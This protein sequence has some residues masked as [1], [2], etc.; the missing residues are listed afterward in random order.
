MP[1]PADIT[2]QSNLPTRDSI[3]RLTACFTWPTNSEA[4]RPRL[5]Y[6]PPD[7]KIRI[8]WT[9]PQHKA[10]LSAQTQLD[11]L[12]GMRCRDLLNDQE[13]IREKNILTSKINGL[14]AKQR[15]TEN[16]AERW[17][18]LAEKAFDFAASAREAFVNGDKETKR[19]TLMSLGSN[20]ILMDGKLS[21]K[22]N[23]WLQPIG[24]A[25]PSLEEEFLRL[26]PAD[27]RMNKGRTE[28]F[29][30]VRSRW[31]PGRDSNPQPSG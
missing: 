18:G 14:K 16:G 21:L 6:W 8:W 2:K 26:E 17:L 23:L 11:N 29:A 31:L 20:F 22:A 13:Y 24:E 30:S 12:L 5:L 7:R 10:I 1:V 9:G 3:K 15:E 28:A 27:S 25:Y 4:L 19:D